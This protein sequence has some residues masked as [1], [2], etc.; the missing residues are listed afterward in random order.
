[1]NRFMADLTY[2]D[3]KSLVPSEIDTVILPVGTIEAHCCT[4]L[5][6]DVTIPDFIAKN[7]APEIQ[8]LIAPSISYGITRTLRAF[9]GSMTVS[10]K[11]FEVYVGDV[12]IGLF[13]TGFKKAIII[14]GHGGHYDEL[15]DIALRAWELTSG[16]TIIIH[17]W[18]LVESLT[19]EF[20]GESGGHGGIDETAMVLAADPNLVKP[21]QCEDIQSYL[22]RPGTYVF[23]NAAP[24]LL[25]KEGEGY[26]KF[27]EELAKAYANKV[28]NFIIDYVRDVFQAWEKN[29]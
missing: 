1:M 21:K 17:W 23:P 10:P 29:F 8:A 6:T 13:K 25:Y 12:L 19:M 16:Y 28:I 14:N 9:P 11:S 24:L 3:F 20:F 2:Q 18:H 22:V 7:L 26:P 27:D 15:K 4:N 5:G